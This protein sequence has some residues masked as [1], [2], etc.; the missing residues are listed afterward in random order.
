V[1]RAREAVLRGVL[2]LVS[3]GIAL[4][5]AEIALRVTGYR[6]ASFGKT[7]RVAN[8]KRTLMLDCY[9]SNP[10][11]YFDV[12][13]RDEA[14]RARYRDA[15]LQ[16]VDAVWTRASACVEYRY[17]SLKLRGP[18]APP[19][20]EGVR[21]V[22]VLGD[23]F[24]EGQGVREDDTYPRV[25]QG[26]LEKDE[27]GRW[28]V[29]NCARRATDFPELY[30]LFDTCL[31]LQPDVL[32]HGMVLNDGE[33]SPEF[34]ARQS[35]LND[36]I[37][38]QARMAEQPEPSFGPLRPRVLALVRDQAESWRVGRESTRWYRDMYGPP[39]AAGWAR[40]QG[41][42]RGMDRR[43]REAGGRFLVASWP[44]LVGLDG[45]YPFED[46]DGTIAA[47]CASAG[48]PRVDLRPALSGRRAETLWVHPVDMHPNEIANRIAAE[49]L[50]PAVREVARSPSR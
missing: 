24:T 29:L 22:V 43:V 11:N 49:T 36:W 46:V 47:F 19:R 41:Y 20:R 23:S 44:L 10:R 2:V 39:N 6:P 35:Y 3:V 9:P 34:E 50:A 15:G 37:T 32:V 42:L 1:T 25:L 26:L 28:E 12:D 33:R 31:A 45:R 40:T 13:L 5:F 17:N 7:A 18:E 16:R 21:R 4:L 8:P 30:R 38:N 14:V 27:P 48:I